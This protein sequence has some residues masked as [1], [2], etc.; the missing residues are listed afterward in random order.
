MLGLNGQVCVFSSG[1][2]IHSRRGRFLFGV[3]TPALFPSHLAEQYMAT[4]FNE[5]LQCIECSHCDE[6]TPLSRGTM[7]DAIRYTAFMEMFRELHK[8]CEGTP[9]EA[10][11]SRR[12]REMVIRSKNPPP[13]R[14]LVL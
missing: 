12:W 14:M 1:W 8:D 4:R 9:Y 5:Q 7:R 11:L 13:S 3:E 6:I 2:H 10:Q